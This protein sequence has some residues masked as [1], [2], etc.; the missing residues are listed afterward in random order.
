MKSRAS[1]HFGDKRKLLVFLTALLTLG[2]LGTSFFAY[3]AASHSAI[4]AMQEN[5]LPV[6]AESLV[7]RADAAL[8]RAKSAGR[9]R[10]MVAPGTD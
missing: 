10:V 5:G 6:A 1:D 7:A 4:A 9:N 3:R 2:F 8:L